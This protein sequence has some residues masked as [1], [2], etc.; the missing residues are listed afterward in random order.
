MNRQKAI[1]EVKHTI[2][3]N[4]R[5]LETKQRITMAEINKEK[6]MLDK[7]EKWIDF[8]EKAED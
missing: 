6:E 3:L 4:R 2:L 7:A 8:I 1:E 5:E